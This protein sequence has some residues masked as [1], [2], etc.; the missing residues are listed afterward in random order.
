MSNTVI[1]KEKFPNAKLFVIKGSWGWGGVTHTK[2][3]K[4]KKYV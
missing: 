3:D 1:T 2:Y 4:I